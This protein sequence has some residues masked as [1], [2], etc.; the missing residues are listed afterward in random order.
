MNTVK[1]VD[2]DILMHRLFTTEEPWGDM[3]TKDILDGMPVLTL[4]IP[5]TFIR[6]SV[7]FRNH[8]VGAATP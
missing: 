1:V 5:D 8:N 2:L 3:D 6:S 7:E 4:R